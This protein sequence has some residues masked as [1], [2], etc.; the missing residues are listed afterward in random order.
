M[1]SFRIYLFIY[2]FVYD[3][4]II[5]ST[6]SVRCNKYTGRD[7]RTAGDGRD[8]CRLVDGDDVGCS[9]ASMDVGESLPAVCRPQR[10]A[11]RY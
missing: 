1:R 8:S 10:H 7:G 9:D 3:T 4:P 2:L 6:Q 11:V 5:I